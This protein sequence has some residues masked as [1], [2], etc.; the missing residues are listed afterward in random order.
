MWPV[1]QARA[2]PGA[3]QHAP[4]PGRRPRFPRPRLLDQQHPVPP[5]IA[6]ILGGHVS[7]VGVDHRRA[8]PLDQ[9]AGHNA[10][11]GPPRVL[12]LRLGPVRVAGAMADV[13]VRR[14]ALAAGRAFPKVQ[15][16]QVQPAQFTDPQAPVRQPCHRQGIAGTAHRGQQLV[17]G[18]VGENLMTAVRATVYSGLAGTAVFTCPR[19]D[20]RRSARDEACS[21]SAASRARCCRRGKTGAG[22]SPSNRPQR[23]RACPGR[24]GASARHGSPSGMRTSAPTRPMYLSRSRS[25]TVSRPRHSRSS[26]RR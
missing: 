14:A 23:S 10:V 24:T 5:L 19:N 12:G 17:P 2:F 6:G 8:D 7:E 21:R 9:P 25:V 18:P 3:C 1:A 15:V 22:R 11:L 20:R 4:G 26:H 13:Q 16:H